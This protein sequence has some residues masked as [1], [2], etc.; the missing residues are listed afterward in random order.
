MPKLSSFSGR[1]SR[2]GVAFCKAFANRWIAVSAE[3]SLVVGS[4]VL[5]IWETIPG[6]S[7]VAAL[8]TVDSPKAP[9][10]SHILSL[11]TFWNARKADC[12]PSTI[13][14]S[15]AAWIDPTA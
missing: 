12:R 10:F 8:V 9:T 6:M 5:A 13:G 2:N 3:V 11:S 15:I 7:P 1:R 14:I 4:M